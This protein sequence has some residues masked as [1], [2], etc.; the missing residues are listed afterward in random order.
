MSS[1]RW[2][3]VGTAVRLSSALELHKSLG[4]EAFL[5]PSMSL[6]LRWVPFF[7]V[8]QDGF[9]ESF[10][11]L[12]SFGEAGYHEDCFSSKA[13]ACEAVAKKTGIDSWREK[14]TALIIRTSNQ[15]SHCKGVAGYFFAFQLSFLPT[16]WTQ[17]SSSF[18]TLP[19]FSTVATFAYDIFGLKAMW[20]EKHLGQAFITN[21]SAWQWAN[22]LVSCFNLWRCGVAFCAPTVLDLSHV[23]SFGVGVGRRHTNS[24]DWRSKQSV[25]WTS[26]LNDEFGQRNISLQ[27]VGT[28]KYHT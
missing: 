1:C 5:H 28:Q 22:V 6:W 14:W 20:N 17:G 3:D 13:K 21:F 4:W 2:S 18:D 12:P 9:R 11:L 23:E 27:M 26:C 8:L 10:S 16:S 24:K 15:P 25:S 19:G 7:R